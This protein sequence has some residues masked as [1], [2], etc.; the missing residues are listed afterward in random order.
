MFNH[1]TGKR[2]IRFSIDLLG[3]CMLFVLATGVI[4][5]QQTPSLAKPTGDDAKISS[6]LSGVLNK[7]K[8]GAKP[9]QLSNKMVK[10]NNGGEVQVYVRVS[11]SSAAS[12]QGLSSAGLKI[13]LVNS[14]I[15]IVQGWIAMS[16]IQGLAALSGVQEITTPGYPMLHNVGSAGTQGYAQ[17]R[18]NW[19]HDAGDLGAGVKIGLI[20]DS[21][22]SLSQ[23]QAT[24]DLPATIDIDPVRPGGN[25][26]GNAG[27]P[28]LEIVHDI[29][30]SSSLAFSG[31]TT[32]LEFIASVNWL[33]NTAHC[34]VVFDDLGFYDEPFFEDG[35]IAQAVWS[36]T[37]KA[38]YISAAGNDNGFHYRGTYTD[39]EPSKSGWPNNLHAFSGK[40]V[41]M[42][43]VIPA[44]ETMVAVLQW[45]NKWGSASDDY[46]LY[47]YDNNATKSELASSNGNQSKVKTPYEAFAYTNTSNS[48]LTANVM[49]D[50]VSGSAQ[51]LELYCWGV[52]SMQFATSSDTIFG[53]PAAP[54]VLS[55]GAVNAATTTTI[56]SYSS[57][58]P[59]TVA[60]PAS[61]TRLTPSFVAVDAVS[62][63]GAGCI[64]KTFKGTS[65]AAAHAA[66]VAALVK[67]ANPNFT[68][69]NIAFMMVSTAT[70]LGVAGHDTI[71]GSGL[72]NAFKATGLKRNA[73]HQW[74]Q[75]K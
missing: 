73:V 39:V 16:A 28:L 60:F 57:Q 51:T 27:T 22:T 12:L 44:H 3:L 20:S 35:P 68:P 59:S 75:F 64:V 6:L 69:N 47:L 17:L 38:V 33:V 26:T 37:S 40:D 14:D 42:Q 7:S 11:D 50:K 70:D 8:V 66:G 4:H 36:V 21:L 67:A 71:F 63:S 56:E 10:V 19:V 1:T 18:A 2:A 49:I 41:T 61:I 24:K 23:A 65:A 34:D 43:V 53:H 62:V 9:A 13:E 74:T 5:A 30:P 54:N 46:D 15:N 32:S 55:V 31:P 48:P 29:A 25:N 52:S 45:T 58:G 72:L